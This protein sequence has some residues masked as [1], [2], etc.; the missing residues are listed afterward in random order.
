M[1]AL[2]LASD[3]FEE[4]ELLVPYYRILEE[5]IAVDI[6]APRQGAIRGKHGYPID[7]NRSLG[8]IDPN[9][10]ALLI[11][12]GGGAAETLAEDPKAIRIA[13]FFLE[14]HKLVA[15]IC[16]GPLVLAATGLMEDRHATGHH[17]IAFALRSARV[18][19]DGAHEVI[20]DD[21][22]ITSRQPEDLPAFMREVIKHV[23]MQ[24]GQT[25]SA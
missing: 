8:E 5:H 22:V 4:A 11:I 9:D 6:A 21:H 2:I 15:A 12:P 3:N 19:Y 25:V 10:Y 16:H 23:R 18:H 7:A 20:V 24:S 14:E 1:K 13:Q 17:S